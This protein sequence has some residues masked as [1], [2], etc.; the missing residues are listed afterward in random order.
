MRFECGLEGLVSES[1]PE[2]GHAPTGQ[3]LIALPMMNEE[4]LDNG[5]KS[6]FDFDGP[7]FVSKGLVGNGIAPE[8]RLSDLDARFEIR[9][10]CTVPCTVKAVSNVLSPF[11]YKGFLE[12]NLGAPWIPSKNSESGS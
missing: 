2:K 8:N 10:V 3:Q 4:V 5:E 11:A 6:T 9:A 1:K 7:G 12:L